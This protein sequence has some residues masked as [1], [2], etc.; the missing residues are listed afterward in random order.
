MKKNC[1]WENNE[2]WRRY[3]SFPLG[4]DSELFSDV[5]KFFTRPTSRLQSY[6]F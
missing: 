5:F 3:S 4:S 2:K 6:G 1:R